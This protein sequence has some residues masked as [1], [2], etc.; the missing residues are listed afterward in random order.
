MNSDDPSR[1]Y[2]IAIV[3]FVFSGDSGESD[4]LISVVLRALPTLGT[5][6]VKNDP[7]VILVFGSLSILFYGYNGR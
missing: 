2:P 6:S 5:S 7:I 3:Y 1:I 4:G